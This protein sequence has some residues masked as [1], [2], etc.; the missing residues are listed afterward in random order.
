MVASAISIA[1][2]LAQVAP[3]IVRWLTGNEKA[4][5]A[6]EAVVDIARSVTGARDPVEALAR[7]KSDA[8]IAMQYR[9]AIINASVALDRAYLAD[10][11]SARKRDI[12]IIRMGG[13]NLRANILLA[14][15]AAGALVVIV[16]LAFSDIDA[17][18]ALGGALLLALGKFLGNLETA[19]QFE[20][21]SSRGSKEKDEILGALT[22]APDPDLEVLTR[23][24]AAV[25]VKPDADALAR[26]RQRLKGKIDD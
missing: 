10:R 1:V 12:A 3:E 18:S 13:T 24:K 14:F 25:E 2:A 15:V 9:M 19:F 4:A 6:A 11:D 16:V 22:K 20:F 23:P 7:I 8:Q 17:S 5:D 21:G 26:V